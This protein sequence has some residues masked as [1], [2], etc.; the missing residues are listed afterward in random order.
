MAPAPTRQ[1]PGNGPDEPAVAPHAPKRPSRRSPSKRPASPPP[2]PE[3]S[4]PP[5][6]LVIGRVAGAHGVR[7]AFKMVVLSSHPDHFDQLTSVFV[8]EEQAPRRVRQLQLGGGEALV[9]VDG[10]ATP[11]EAAALRGQLVKIARE[12]AKKLQ[13]G[14]Y[15]YYELLGLEVVDVDGTELGRL[16]EVHETG[17]N[18][19]FIVR[20]PGREVLLPNIS[21]VILDVDLQ[22]GRITARV[23]EYL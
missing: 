11:Q 17:A 2:I 15:Y 9:R 4:S 23:P 3:R 8:G 12:D 21:G 22:A 13:A 10:C 19:V 18:D 1:S 6:R 14:E 20:A 7:G 16:A 5:D